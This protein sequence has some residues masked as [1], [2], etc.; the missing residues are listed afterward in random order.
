[1]T[2]VS[3]SPYRRVL[4][5]PGVRS[6]LLV[7][8]LARVPATALGITLTLHVVNA[9][10]LNWAR[11]GLVTAAYT[12]GAA[13]GQPVT[14]RLLDRKREVREGFTPPAPRPSLAS[15]KTTGRPL[16]S[17]KTQA[18]EPKPMPEAKPKPKAPPKPVGEGTTTSRLLD[19]KRKRDQQESEEQ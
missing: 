16:R 9:M 5:V 17:A 3:L 15:A 14:G 7:G 19:R 1:M 10:G 8:I 12:V 13:I 11:A 2:G 6:L 4:A 18:A